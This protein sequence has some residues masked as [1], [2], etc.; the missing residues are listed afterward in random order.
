MTGHMGMFA[1]KGQVRGSWAVLRPLFRI[2]KV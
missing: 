2:S 1:V